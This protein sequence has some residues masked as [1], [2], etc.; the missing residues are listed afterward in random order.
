MCDDL[1][2]SGMR[3]YAHVWQGHSCDWRNNTT[4][5][6]TGVASTQRVL[7]TA[8]WTVL[9]MV[10]CRPL[11]C[12]QLLFFWSPTVVSCVCVL[13][14]V[15][16]ITP[17][18]QGCMLAVVLRGAAGLA[19]LSMHPYSNPCAHC[20]LHTLRFNL[21]CTCGGVVSLGLLHCLL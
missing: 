19:D 15:T 3:G 18:R 5:P 16:V 17:P 6:A 7:V 14:L 8:K 4:Q 20:N 13:W 21:P 1:H 9:L 2:A 10:W 12:R 11:L